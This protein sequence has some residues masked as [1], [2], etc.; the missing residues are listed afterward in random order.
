MALKAQVVS[1]DE[2]ET[3]GRRSILN[4]GHT[5]GHALEAAAGYGALLHG[6]A[7]AL[8]MI[9]AA[10]IGR[11]LGLTPPAAGRAAAGPAGALRSDVAGARHRRG[12]RAGGDE[13]GQEDRGKDV[14]WVLLE[15][16][17][18]PVLRTDVPASLVRQVIEEMLEQ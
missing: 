8:G 5:V 4:Y 1:E 15:D 3:T 14:R 9:A 7:V 18:Q 2:R 6:E 11:R 10:E 13:P 17:G 12:Q 16:V